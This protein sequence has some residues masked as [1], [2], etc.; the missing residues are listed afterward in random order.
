LLL[1]INGIAI[2][3]T[4][5]VL[6]RL[7]KNDPGGNYDCSKGSQRKHDCGALLLLDAEFPT[8]TRSVQ[9]KF[10]SEGVGIQTARF[11]N[12]W[13]VSVTMQHSFGA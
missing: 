12:S 1:C 9:G 6:A 3:T 10:D 4:W 7:L 13:L 11:F 5:S 8:H 2:V